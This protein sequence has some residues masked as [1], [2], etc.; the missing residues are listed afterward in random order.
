MAITTTSSVSIPNAHLRVPGPSVP[1]ALN[2][3]DRSTTTSPVDSS[4]AIT[5]TLLA[6]HHLPGILLDHGPMAI[7][8]ITAHLIQTLPGFSAI[9]PARQRRLVVGA[10]EGR[11][12][13]NSN[14]EVIFEKVGWGRWDARRK[15]DP[16]RE[17]QQATYSGETGVFIQSEEDEDVE[18]IDVHNE[19]ETASS[20]EEMEEDDDMTDE[21]DWAQMGPEALRMDSF[22]LAF[23]LQIGHLY[24]PLYL[25]GIFIAVGAF[26]CRFFLLLFLHIF[27]FNVAVFTSFI[28][29]CLFFYN[30]NSLQGKVANNVTTRR[31]HAHIYTHTHK[32]D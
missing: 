12:V 21:E 2:S 22:G 25:L 17:R 27:L 6:K 30:L 11:G 18:M 16:P 24:T 13:D 15:G 4:G 20:D 29:Y 28:L 3:A 26:G 10:L 14:S 9:P 19:S 5:P 1:I 7:R 8:Y 31:P 23:C 32:Y